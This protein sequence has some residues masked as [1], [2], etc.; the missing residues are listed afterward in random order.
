MASELSPKRLA[1][2]AMGIWL[3]AIGA[4]NYISGVIAGIAGVPTGTGAQ[5]E[6]HI[7]ELAF[8]DYGWIALAAAALLLATVPILRRLVRG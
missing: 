4:A 5:A 7:Y 6:R 2:M 8:A 3:L 1:G